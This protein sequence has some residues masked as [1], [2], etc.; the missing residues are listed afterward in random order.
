MS[1]CLRTN[2]DLQGTKVR[3]DAGFRSA[4]GRNF[5]LL[6]RLPPFYVKPPAF[7]VR[8]SGERVE[9]R[10]PDED[11]RVYYRAYAIQGF[12]DGECMFL[13][14]RREGSRVSVFRK[15]AYPNV[16]RVLGTA[17]RRL[18]DSEVALL[19]G[20]NRYFAFVPGD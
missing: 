5:L 2:K 7:M 17:F 16:A 3:I 13:R 14:E 9:Q 19:V 6:H 18:A 4:D 20:G 11:S 10:V 12:S 8:V 1:L 15:R